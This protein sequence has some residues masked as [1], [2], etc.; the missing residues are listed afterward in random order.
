MWA[1]PDGRRAAI[2]EEVFDYLTAVQ[3]HFDTQ[4][5]QTI[6][7]GPELPDEPPAYRELKKCEKWGLPRDGGWTDQPAGYMQDVW[8]AEVGVKRFESLQAANQL[9]E[10]RE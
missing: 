7:R 4:Q 2:A 6:Y 8:A 9:A 3:E 1:T 5:H 10:V